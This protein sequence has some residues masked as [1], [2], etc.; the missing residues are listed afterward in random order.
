[1][2]RSI[3][4]IVAAE[5]FTRAAQPVLP[6][7]EDL[8]LRPWLR[9][10]APEVFTAF[11]DPAIQRWH[12]RTA[13]TEEEA[14]DWVSV[15]VRSWHAGRDANW[16]VADSRTGRLLGRASLVGMEL[17]HGTAGVAYWVMPTA[18]GREV[19]PRALA[20]LTAW[21]FDHAGFHRLELRHSVHNAQSCRVAAKCGFALEGVNRSATL[22][23]DGW[24]DM[25]LH[26]RVQDDQPTETR[27]L[28]LGSRPRHRAEP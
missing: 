17:P 27:P 24:H 25:H 16:A 13:E 15:W 10:D 12:R 1:M 2:A 23:A 22:H 9:R 21:A 14:G 8:V 26:A 6:A 28:A 20:A 5:V 3:P 18:R 4:A 7:G 11:Q 19:A